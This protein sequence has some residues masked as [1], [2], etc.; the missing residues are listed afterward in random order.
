MSWV[1]IECLISE[2]VWHAKVTL[3]LGEASDRD[4]KCFTTKLRR[5]T[6]YTV[7]IL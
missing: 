4:S 2:F 3:G 1:G 5:A 6:P 7:L